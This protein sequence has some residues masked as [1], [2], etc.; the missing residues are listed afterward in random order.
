MENYDFVCELGL[1][2]QAWVAKYRDRTSGIEYAAKMNTMKNDY[3]LLLERVFLRK[4][5]TGI[6]DRL[7]KFKRSGDVGGQISFILMEL[8]PD[9]IDLHYAPLPPGLQRD[10][11]IRDVALQMVECIEQLHGI[12]T[13]H[14]DVKPSNFLMKNNRVYITD[15][16]TCID[17][18]NSETG[19]HIR[20]QSTQFKGTLNFAGIRAHNR[21]NQGRRD[22]IESIGYCMLFMLSDG[23]YGWMTN[24]NNDRHITMATN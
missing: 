20:Q 18:K 22:D 21:T 19:E 13:L 6:Y 3:F 9:P 2:G 7:P 10:L 17:W 5:E 11:A 23:Q 16:G 12:G 24:V 15:F 14:R 8:L 4:N 1:G